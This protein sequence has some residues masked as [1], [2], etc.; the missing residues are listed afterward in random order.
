MQKLPILL[1]I[2]IPTYNYDVFSLVENLY[3][4]AIKADIAF[5]ILVFDDAS[6][7]NFNNPKINELAHCSFTV[8]EKNI[9]RSAIRNLLA[10]SAK[11]EWLLLLDA[12]VFPV[13]DT[14]ISTYIEQTKS[15]DFKY[16]SGGIAYKNERPEKDKILRWKYGHHREALLYKDVLKGKISYMIINI[17][18]HKTVFEKVG[19]DEKIRF[20]GYED[21]IFTYEIM[22]LFEVSFIDNPVFHLNEDTSEVFLTKA[23]TSMETLHFLIH[24]NS[25]DVNKVKIA[26]VYMKLKKIGL[27]PI[28][29]FLHRLFKKKMEKNLLSAK[30]SLFLFDL[31]RLGYLCS[32]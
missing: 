20:Y 8:L 29:S 6:Q 32:L 4:Q 27:R 23:K 30:P 17:L 25:I 9:G 10:K 3:K 26:K 15:S 28:F 22:K 5:E 13:N 31:Y 16:F 7:K 11:Y 24:N 18:A 12:D 21:I 1:S 19:F 14:F 2:L